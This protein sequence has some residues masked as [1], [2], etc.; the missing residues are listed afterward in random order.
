MHQEQRAAQ[1]KRSVWQD[2]TT[3]HVTHHTVFKDWSKAV[4]FVAGLVYLFILMPAVL[5]LT[6]WLRP[7]HDPIVLPIDAGVALLG[8]GILQ[9]VTKEYFA[10]R[11]RKTQDEDGALLQAGPASDKLTP[12]GP[13]VAPAP[14]PNG[15]IVG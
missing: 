6:A 4:A 12:Q 14:G 5:L 7:E 11:D 2:I 1:I 13:P 8:T 15:G 9:Q 3:D 10:Q